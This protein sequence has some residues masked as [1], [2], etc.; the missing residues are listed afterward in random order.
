MTAHRRRRVVTVSPAAIIHRDAKPENMPDDTPPPSLHA[1]TL[2]VS[3]DLAR[4]EVQARREPLE[5]GCWAVWSDPRRLTLPLR[6]VY[7]V[8]GPVFETD[9]EGH[10]VSEQWEVSPGGVVN[11][12]YLTRVRPGNSGVA[13]RALAARLHELEPITAAELRATAVHVERMAEL[14]RVWLERPR[15]P[16]QQVSGIGGAMLTA[17]AVITAADR[18]RAAIAERDQLV[19]VV[20]PTLARNLYAA[21]ALKMAAT[22]GWTSNAEGIENPGW[23][24]LHAPRRTT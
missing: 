12:W 7:V 5:P 6:L 21:G 13:A 18:L 10:A 24:A 17:G 16:D 11:R 3:P 9:P 20:L 8:D 19:Q 15:D 1:H 22:P 14:A 23:K 4:Y 2:A